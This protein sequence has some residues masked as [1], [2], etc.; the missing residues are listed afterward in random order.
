ML[1]RLGPSEKGK[2]IA[3]WLLPDFPVGCRRLTPG[4]GFLEA[5]GQDNVE[6]VWDGIASISETGILTSDGRHLDIDAIICATGFDCSYQPRFQ[7]I[8]RNDVSLAQRWQDGD[9]ECYFGT[10]VSGFPN[11]FM[12]IGPNSPISNGGLVQGIQAQAIYIY[13]CIDKMQTQTIRSMD[14]SREAMDDYNE[15]SQAYLRTSVWAE[16][17]S[18]WYK[19]GTKDGRV[20]AIYAGS[21]FHFVAMMRHPR[22]EDYVFDYVD[23]KASNRFAFL[24]NGFTKREARDMTI[25]DTQTLDFEDFWKLMELPPIYD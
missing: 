1:E 11:Y 10:M 19:R 2:K 21:A 16:A 6:C 20:V 23:G 4:P 18:S 8:G 9:P 12:F 24:G 17:C 15:H 14:V 25:G 13:K 7:L 3:E 5:L 22:W